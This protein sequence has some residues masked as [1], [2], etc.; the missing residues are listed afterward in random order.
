MVPWKTSI[1]QDTIVDKIAVIQAFSWR[2][3]CQLRWRMRCLFIWKAKPFFHTELQHS[4]IHEL[5]A[6]FMKSLISIHAK[7]LIVS[8]TPV[9]H[10][11]TLSNCRTKKAKEHKSRAPSI[12]PQNARK[13][14][15]HRSLI[16]FFPSIMKQKGIKKGTDPAA[17]YFPGP[18]PAKYHQRYRA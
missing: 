11:R 17:T 7:Q 14:A 2:R 12:I 16:S 1:I 13:T 15:N 10:V 9:C 8:S 18:S 6:Q 3:M 4:S 5:K